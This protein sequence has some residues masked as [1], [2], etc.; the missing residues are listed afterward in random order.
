MKYF[1]LLIIILI[2]P[3]I[4]SSRNRENNIVKPEI[5]KIIIWGG[6][7]YNDG[8][9]QV[10][11][12][13]NSEFSNQGIKAEYKRYINDKQG[14]LKLD[15][16]LLG[17]GDIDLFFSYGYEQYSRR[18]EKM[19]LNLGSLIT[20]DNYDIKKYIG[21][22]GN[23]KSLING[24]YYGLA[25]KTYNNGFL[26]NKN[27]FDSAG[28]EIPIKWNWNDFFKT[29]GKLSSVKNGEKIYG[30]YLGTLN[31]QEVPLEMLDSEL[32]ADHYYRNNG[33]SV[34]FS[35]P[36]YIKV[37][38]QVKSLMGQGFMPN[39]ESVINHKIS[40]TQLFT[41]GKTAMIYGT[42][43]I[44]DI[45]N[46]EKYPHDFV[47]AYVPFPSNSNGIYYNSGGPGDMLQINK[48]SKKIKESWLF[49]KWYLEK[50][51][52][53]MA[54]FGRIPLHP[55]FDI[56]DASK[57]LLSGDEDLFHVESI[58]NGYLKPSQN[59]S[60]PFYSS[61]IVLE[62]LREELENFYF[63]NITAKEALSNAESKANTALNN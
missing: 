25:S 54:R 21:I 58:N 23:K 56:S 8:P 57:G 17:G 63:G 26:A 49:I 30:A 41:Q 51:V 6:V 45:K 53:E 20:N 14:N 18:S 44:R 42:W 50:G 4:F 52:M 62:I 47:T 24:E 13:F 9:K 39:Q 32:G 22:F 3:P 60:I 36:R 19:A 34:D 46:R 27:M 2:T 16:T 55:N 29:V 5:T 7:P 11:Q 10:I 15:V 40:G 38:N 33:K 31:L 48:N 35:N 61:T 1:I 43:L 37:L 28:I 12:L 59:Y